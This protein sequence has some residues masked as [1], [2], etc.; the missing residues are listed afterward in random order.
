[1]DV[2]RDLETLTDAPA[3]APQQ[4]APALASLCVADPGRA[5]PTRAHILRAGIS[6]AVMGVYNSLRLGG[7]LLR[8][9]T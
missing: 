6:E 4:P 1:L 5:H 8:P 9:D 2:A 7:L 3:L